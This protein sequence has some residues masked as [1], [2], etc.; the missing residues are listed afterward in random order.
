MPQRSFLLALGFA[1]LFAPFLSAA[2]CDLQ[3][4][5]SCT[6][7]HC[8][9]VTTNVGQT[10]CIGT[11]VSLFSA[12]GNVTLSGITTSLGLD[13][14]FSAGDF[15]VPATTAW[16]ACLGDAALGAGASFTADVSAASPG[17]SS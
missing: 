16:A 10:T 2:A 14:C 11:F 9:S 12:Q 6:S 8:R 1:L 13:Q 17:G 5:V 15:G 3:I 4:T 7:G